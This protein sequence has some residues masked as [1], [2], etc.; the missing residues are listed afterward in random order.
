MATTLGDF[1]GFG[2]LLRQDLPQLW[3][4]LSWQPATFLRLWIPEALAEWP[5]NFSQVW[6]NRI[7]NV[8]RPSSQSHPLITGGMTGDAKV[9]GLVVVS[10]V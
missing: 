4:S 7:G 10:Q 5:D 2:R 3:R 9:H 1:S 6:K 8:S